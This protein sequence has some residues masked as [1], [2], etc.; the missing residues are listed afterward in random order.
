LLDLSETM[1]SEAVPAVQRRSDQLSFRVGSVLELPFET[2]KFDR[3]GCNAWLLHVLIRGN[4]VEMKRVLFTGEKSVDR[5]RLGHAGRYN[6]RTVTRTAIQR[7][8]PAGSCEMGSSYES[9]SRPTSRA[10]FD[11]S[12]AAEVDRADLMRFIHGL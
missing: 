11:N 3:V 10:G 7:A 8:S 2:G 1:I 4:T 12:H 5:D 9:C 6:R